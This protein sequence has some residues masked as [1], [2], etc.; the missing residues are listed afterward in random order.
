MEVDF[1]TVVLCI[2][3]LIA[4]GIFAADRGRNP[5]IWPILCTLFP[6][7]GLIILALIP[8]FKKVKCP[9][10]GKEFTINDLEK[11]KLNQV[12]SN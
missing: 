1:L 8:N 6:M 7:G 12:L 2:A 11:A 4:V 10:C 3:Y 5:L 9:A